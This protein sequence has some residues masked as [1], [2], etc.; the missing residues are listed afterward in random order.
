[1]LNHIL[2]TFNLLSKRNFIYLFIYEKEF[3]IISNWIKIIIII[4]K[5]KKQTEINEEF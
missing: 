1:M 2:V 4:R 5:G 3:H